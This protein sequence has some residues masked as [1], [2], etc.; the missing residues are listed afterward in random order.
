ILAE[1]GIGRRDSK[2]RQGCR[3]DVVDEAWCG[4]FFRAQATADCLVAFEYKDARVLFSEDC[5]GDQC[6]DASS[7]DGIVISAHVPAPPSFGRHHGLALALQEY[8]RFPESCR[9]RKIAW[10]QLSDCA[11]SGCQLGR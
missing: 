11:S 4:N 9:S 1:S 7:D 3:H 6:V 10:S 2:P 8:A 5:G